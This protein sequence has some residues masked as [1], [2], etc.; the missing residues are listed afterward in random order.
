MPMAV[1]RVLDFGQ[2]GLDD[3][4]GLSLSAMGHFLF[5]KLSG[6]LESARLAELQ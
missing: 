6:W 2:S 3:S 1:R 5:R 4:V